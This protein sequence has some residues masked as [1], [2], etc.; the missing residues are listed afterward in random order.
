MLDINPFHHTKDCLPLSRLYFILSV[1]SFVVQQLLIGS[2]LF[3]FSFISFALG[4]RSKE[5]FYDFM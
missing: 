4:N 1:V 3:T 5:Y 2:H